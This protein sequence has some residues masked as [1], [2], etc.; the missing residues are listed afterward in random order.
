MAGERTTSAGGDAVSVLLIGADQVDA[1]K[2]ELAAA[3]LT[4]VEH[5]SGRKPGDRKR[6]LPHDTG[7]LVV[8]TDFVSH[9]LVR[10]VREDAARR[11][12]DVLYCR[13]SL[14]EVRDKLRR[15]ADASSRRAA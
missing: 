6:A 9:G 12:V 7:L 10:K 11:H 14:I 1:I 8:M 5:W 4:R 3:G 13:R 15:W 2:K